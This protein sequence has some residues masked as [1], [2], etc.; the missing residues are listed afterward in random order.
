[1]NKATRVAKVVLK[2]SSA[3]SVPVIIH[4]DDTIQ[5]LKNRIHSEAGIHVDFN[6]M[7]NKGE[8]VT[9][10]QNVVDYISSG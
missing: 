5:D 8:R 4:P 2:N 9:D 6:Q 7:N 3:E 10:N 1:M